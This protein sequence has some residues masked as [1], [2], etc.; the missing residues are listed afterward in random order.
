M[1]NI[2]FLVL[3]L[4]CVNI[5]GPVFLL[6]NILIEQGCQFYYGPFQF[7]IFRFTSADLTQPSLPK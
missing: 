1:L 4:F 6:E 2:E 5:G 3:Q 7:S